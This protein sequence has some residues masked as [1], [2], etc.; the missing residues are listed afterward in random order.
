[1][2]L[3]FIASE[4]TMC[5][6]WI[7]IIALNDFLLNIKVPIKGVIKDTFIASPIYLPRF[8]SLCFPNLNENI[9]DIRLRI[10]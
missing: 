4:I 3:G 2:N 10:L 5:C 1:M 9:K 7:F 8:I 6:V